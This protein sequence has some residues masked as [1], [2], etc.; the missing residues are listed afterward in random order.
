[1]VIWPFWPKTKAKNFVLTFRKEDCSNCCCPSWTEWG[2]WVCLEQREMERKMEMVYQL[3]SGLFCLLPLQLKEWGIYICFLVIWWTIPKKTNRKFLLSIIVCIK[4]TKSELYWSVPNGFGRMFYWFGKKKWTI[5]KRHKDTHIVIYLYNMC[6]LFVY[7]IH[8][9]LWCQ[10]LMV[11]CK[12]F[13][14]LMVY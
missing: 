10:S 12:F 11:W 3:G 13:C 8:D 7:G 9:S 1:M 6:F 5:L 4:I 14:C 2:F